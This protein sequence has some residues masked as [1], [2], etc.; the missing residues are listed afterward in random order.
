MIRLKSEIVLLI[1]PTFIH[2]FSGIFWLKTFQTWQE[3]HYYGTGGTTAHTTV[4]IYDKIYVLVVKF[5][6]M[7]RKVS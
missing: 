5:T 3:S 7:V 6:T 4:V 1:V 2:Y